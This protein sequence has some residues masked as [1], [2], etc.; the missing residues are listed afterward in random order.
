MKRIVASLMAAMLL[1]A[2]GCGQNVKPSV[3]VE[4]PDEWGI[5]LRAEDVT[6]TGLTVVCTQS[7][8]K[9]LTNLNTGRM[10]YLEQMKKGTWE[11]LPT[12]MDR[13]SWNLDALGVQYEGSVEWEVG[14]KG[15]YGELPPGVYRIAKHI[16]GYRGMGAFTTKTYY[17]EFTIVD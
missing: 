1:F 12:L 15:L 5:T 10:F 11:P 13:V 6:P 4:E 2:A 17:A 7:G 16:E 14:W 8:G 3:S 9:P